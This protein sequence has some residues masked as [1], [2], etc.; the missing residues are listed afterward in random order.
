[1]DLKYDPLKNKTKTTHFK[2]KIK[3]TTTHIS[4]STIQMNMRREIGD[5]HEKI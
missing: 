5:K 2:Y 1:M 4:T 3:N